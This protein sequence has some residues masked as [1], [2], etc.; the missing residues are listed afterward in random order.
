MT[1]IRI[2]NDCGGEPRLAEVAAACQ[3]HE[4]DDLDLMMRLLGVVRQQ[5]NAKD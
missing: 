5:V 4:F 2:W 3:L 1:A